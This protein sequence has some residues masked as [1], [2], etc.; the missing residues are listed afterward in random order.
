MLFNLIDPW[1]VEQKWLNNNKK[2]FVRASGEAFGF[3]FS[4]NWL[5]LLWWSLAIFDK[6]FV[7]MVGTPHPSHVLLFIFNTILFPITRK[8]KSDNLI[9]FHSAISY[10]A[11][12]P[13][14]SKLGMASASQ[15]GNII[16]ILHIRRPYELS[17]LIDVSCV[18][19]LENPLIIFSS[20]PF[21]LLALVETFLIHWYF[22]A[23]PKVDLHCV[24]NLL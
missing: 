9:T 19:L 12:A 1:S 11:K 13:P 15:E 5:A 20:M 23:D 8:N 21:S 4:P 18:R 22:L 7:T 14:N 2:I 10:K 16:D 24:C 6:L 3:L 17:V